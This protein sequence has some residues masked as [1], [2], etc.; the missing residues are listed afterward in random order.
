MQNFVNFLI[1]RQAT[2][3]LEV[4]ADHVLCSCGGRILVLS[5]KLQENILWCYQVNRNLYLWMIIE[6]N[7]F[8]FW[9]K[10]FM[11]QQLNLNSFW[12]CF[13]FKHQ[14]LRTTF[15]GAIPMWTF[16]THV[17]LESNFIQNS[18]SIMPS[19]HTTPRD[20]NDS[21]IHP[22]LTTQANHL[23]NKIFTIALHS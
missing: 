13:L 1:T 3:E 12:F 21:P 10:H 4:A 7:F 6:S 2:L 15:I 14:N 20:F 11:S 22:S 5:E 18:Q 19:E 8:K 23:P 16:K 17:K 9:D